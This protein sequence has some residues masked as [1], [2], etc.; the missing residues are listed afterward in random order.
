MRPAA[1]RHVT[2]LYEQHL[3]L[4]TDGAHSSKQNEETNK[5]T[6]KNEKEGDKGNRLVATE[7]IVHIHTLRQN[8]KKD[9]EKRD[10]KKGGGGG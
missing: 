1:D 4:V 6:N 5:R 2:F 10:G 9:M 8:T 7:A 3:Q